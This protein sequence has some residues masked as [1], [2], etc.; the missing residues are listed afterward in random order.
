MVK[1]G[2][3]IFKFFYVTL[4]NC[5]TATEKAVHVVEDL[6]NVYREGSDIMIS[7]RSVNQVIQASD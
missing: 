7:S 6:E 1:L 5:Q 2:S 4:Y 3:A